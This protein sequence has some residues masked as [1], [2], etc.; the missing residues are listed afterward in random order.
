MEVKVSWMCCSKSCN[1]AHDIPFSVTLPVGSESL[2]DVA[3]ATVFDEARAKV[4]K[5]DPRWEAKAKRKGDKV[6]LEMRPREDSA[7]R[8]ANELGEMRFFTADGL[9]DSDAAQQVEVQPDGSLR[10]ELVWSEFGPKQ[11]T[12]LHGV[13]RASGGWRSGGPEFIELEAAYAEDAP[14]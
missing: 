6:L 14:E 1:P 9:V 5:P 8:N 7:K 11:P 10:W 2:K 13:V 4:P 12:V 3:V